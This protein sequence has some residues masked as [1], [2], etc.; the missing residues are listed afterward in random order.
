MEKWNLIGYGKI[1]FIA[2][3]SLINYLDPIN[4]GQLDNLTLLT[5]TLGAYL[6]WTIIGTLI[7]LVVTK[8]F[9]GTIT[10]PNWSDNPLRLKEPF[11][12]LQFI[13]IATIIFGLANMLGVF[14]KYTDIGL[15][16]LQNIFSGLGV[17]TSMKVSE[18]LLNG[19]TIR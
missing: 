1:G 5:T 11:I 17:L 13:G 12:L 4:Y 14:V 2:L 9:N 15:V 19:T 7:T 6:G 18:R 3:F 8:L 10:K 16:G